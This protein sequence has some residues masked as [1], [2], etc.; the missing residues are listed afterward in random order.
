GT[1][2]QD[3]V[4]AYAVQMAQLLMQR[5]IKALVIACNTATTAALNHLQ[6]ILKDIPVLGVVAPGA[7]A[8]VHATRNQRI[9]VLAT[10]TTIAAHAYQDLIRQR[11]PNVIIHSKACSVLVALAEEGMVDNAIT[12]ETLKHYLAELTDEDTILLGCTHFPVFKNALRSLVS[13]HVQLVDSADATAEALKQ[14]LQKHDLCHAPLKRGEVHYMVTDS[15]GRFQK[16]GEIFL[17]ESLLAH[18]IELIDV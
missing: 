4:K 12:R 17:Q 5:Q 7:A 2:S 10:E 15:V 13:P 16:V 14:C 11:L 9:A 1:K 8:A 6:D 18:E 3:T